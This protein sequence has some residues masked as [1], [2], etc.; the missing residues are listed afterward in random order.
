MSDVFETPSWTA[1][2]SMGYP[3]A[4]VMDVLPILLRILI[5]MRLM[6]MDE[7]WM[8]LLSTQIQL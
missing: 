2:S 5:C 8:R 1:S 3:K 7:V 6:V 4:L